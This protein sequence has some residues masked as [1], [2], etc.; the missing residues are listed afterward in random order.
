MKKVISFLMLLSFISCG[1]Q[2]TK[3][4]RQEVKVIEQEKPKVKTY[5]ILLSTGK[6]MTIEADSYSMYDGFFHQGDTKYTFYDSKN[7]VIGTFIN[8]VY[9]KDITK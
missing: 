6:T 1:N 9:V 7:N 4:N 3:V 2:T 8:P 5:E